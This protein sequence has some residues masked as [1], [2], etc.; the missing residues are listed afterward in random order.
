VVPAKFFE[1]LRDPKRRDARGYVLPSSQADFPTATKFVNALQRSGIDVHRATREFSVAGKSYPAGSLVVKSAQAFRPHVLDMFEPQDH[2]N[3][4]AAPGGPP[5]P[6]YD[7]AGWTLAYQMGVEFDRILDGFDGPFEKLVDLAKPPAATVANASGAA[8][9]LIAARANDSF[10]VANRLLKAGEEVFRVKSGADAGSF[11]VTASA[12]ATPILQKAA[13]ELGVGANGVSARPAGELQRLKQLRIGLWDRYGGSMPSGWIRWLLEQYEFPCEVVFPQGLDAGNLAS[14]FDVLILPADAV[15]ERD[16]REG[17]AEGG[18][19]DVFVAR[20]PA[21][22]RLPDEFKGWLGRVTVAKT[23]PQLKAFLEAGGTVLT[24]GGSTVLAR[25][26]GLPVNDHLVD[27]TTTPER[28]LSREKFYVPGSVL[29]VAVD[30]SQPLAWGMAKEADILYD[31][32]P[33][34][35]LSPDAALRGVKP[36]AWFGSV[37]P[38]RS[39]WAWGQHYLDGGVAVADAEVGRGRLLLFGP[40]ITFRG[41]PHGTFKLLFNGI[42]R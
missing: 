28:R 42:Y 32:S 7:N 35:R 11:Y 24:I 27:R 34:M 37:E 3:D 23:V 40:E 26:L 4:F 36:V 15:P 5:I 21:P 22:E 39:G 12:K 20:Q 16:A 17:A 38:L 14:R 1:M 8:G 31:N 19:G 2:P 13:A 30:N 9:F 18:G 25:H 41:Q 6:P 33:V 10:L 29:R